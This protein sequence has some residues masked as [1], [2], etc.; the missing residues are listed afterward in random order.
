MSRD[1]KKYA[2]EYLHQTGSFAY[3]ETALRHLAEEIKVEVKNAGGN[4]E[5]AGI[6]QMLL[7][8]ALQPKSSARGVTKCAQSER[9]VVRDLP[10][11]D[12]VS[13]SYKPG[14]TRW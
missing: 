8:S 13:S 10:K 11:E 6:I 14:T 7:D 3:T 9:L 4:G 12:W 1:L 5:L 2:V